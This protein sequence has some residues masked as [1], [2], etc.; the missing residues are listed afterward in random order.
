[1]QAYTHK[2]PDTHARTESLAD[3]RTHSFTWTSLV[4]REGTRGSHAQRAQER[5]RASRGTRRLGG[6]QSTERKKTHK[7][8]ETQARVRVRVFVDVGVGVMDRPHRR[9][10]QEQQTQATQPATLNTP[11]RRKGE[12]EVQQR[13]P[14]CR[15]QR[16]VRQSG[17]ERRGEPERARN[18]RQ[19]KRG[20]HQGRGMGSRTELATRTRREWR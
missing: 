6:K 10:R 17:D 8:E 1:M 16:M 12:G 4:T 5:V 11:V 3:T 19:R 18:T 9:R 13:C 7:D 14:S 15:A 2:H 20:D